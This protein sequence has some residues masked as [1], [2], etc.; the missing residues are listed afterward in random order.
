MDAILKNIEP[1]ILIMAMGGL[2][3]LIAAALISYALWPQF[4]EYRKSL[5]TLTLLEEAAENGNSLG[6]E[7]A[8]IE[9]EITT[10]D[11]NLHG[12]M[13]DLPARQME[14]YIIGRL[15]EISWENNIKLLGV[16]PN[17]ANT[18]KT[19]E[20]IPFDVEVSGDYFD[21]FAWLQNL[22]TELGFVVIKHFNIS[23]LNSSNMAPDLKAS[24]TI[25]SYREAAND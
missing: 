3:L 18:I 23:P 13:V 21:L 19:F 12:E 25:V 20:E 16:R 11:H 14:A 4:K 7:I 6:L 10:L 24:L 5:H 8:T 22:G 2:F 15:Q 1:R 17:K 9:K